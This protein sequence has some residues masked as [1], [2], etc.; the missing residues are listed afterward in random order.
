MPSPSTI[1]KLP[2]AVL[3]ELKRRL[4]S[5]H[6]DILGLSQWLKDSGYCISRSAVGRYSVKLKQS[7]Q[8]LGLDREIMALC[9]YD[10]AGLFEELAKLKKRESEIIEQLQIATLFRKPS[11]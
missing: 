3:V 1:T 9:E 8:K 10:V 4:R 11:V 2:N 6:F 7:D 5:G